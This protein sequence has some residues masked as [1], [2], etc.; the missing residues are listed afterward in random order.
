MRF[1][2][3]TNESDRLGLSGVDEKIYFFI[4]SYGNEGVNMGIKKMSEKFIKESISTVQRGLNRL[5]NRGLV[6]CSKS[7]Y[8]IN[9]GMVNHY[10]VPQVKM[11]EGDSSKRTKGTIKMNEG[12]SSKRT[13]GTIKMNECTPYNNTN[14]I[15][16]DNTN[17]I[18]RGNATAEI[19]SISELVLIKWNEHYAQHFNTGYVPD[20]RSLTN[21]K[22]LISDA[23][24]NKMQ[25][26]K[27]NPD[28]ADEA[29]EFIQA[30]FEAM[31]S[32][33]DKW[34]KEHWTLHT[35]ATQFNQLYN[36]IINRKNGNN[37]SNNNGGIT[38]DYIARKMREAGLL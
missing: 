29:A 34:Q 3:D 15:Q 4:K 16:T 33:A 11:N 19:I 1:F 13:K 7:D 38:D 10:C 21:D 22:D 8:I 18:Q 28:N 14:N 36:A 37:N 26:F 2:F 5:I 35:V 23:V 24:K 30:M 31:F 12:D 27:K 20:Y 32:A 6:I 9:G 25:D 17:N